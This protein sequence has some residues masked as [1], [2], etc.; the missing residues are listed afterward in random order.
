MEPR[1]R[2]LV[3]QRARQRRF[4]DEV[5]LRTADRCHVV[6]CA[7]EQPLGRHHHQYP[8]HLGQPDCQQVPDRQHRR[9]EDVGRGA[10]S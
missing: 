7:G 3:F 6:A 10:D 1:S 4:D 9:R 2:Q 8:V 5:V